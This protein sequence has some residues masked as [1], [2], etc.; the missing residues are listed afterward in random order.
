M[1]VALNKLAALWFYVTGIVV[2]VSSSALVQ[3]VGDVSRTVPTIDAAEVA[4]VAATV[5]L[6]CRREEV[7][8]LLAL[9]VCRAPAAPPP[10]ED[11]AQILP[12]RP[13]HMAL[14][15]VNYR[16]RQHHICTCCCC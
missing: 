14:S 7:M 2:D 16:K 12:V 5:S 1:P 6:H 10:P 13:Q 9:G 4:F 11:V 15:R 3:I 8:L